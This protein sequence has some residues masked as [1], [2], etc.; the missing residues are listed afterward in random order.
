MAAPLRYSAV[1]FDLDGTLV[2]SYEALTDAVNHCLSAFDRPA[3]TAEEIRQHVGEGVETLLRRC[4]GDGSV[5]AEAGRIFEDRYDAVCCAGSRMLEEVEVTLGQLARR[6]VRMG[7]CTNKP[8]GFSRKI[9]EHLGVAAHFAAIVGPDLAGARKPDAAH[10]DFVLS[11]ISADPGESLFVG[12]MPIDV[13]A[14]RNAGLDVAVIATGSSSPEDL[15]RETPDF[16]LDRFSELME[17][18]RS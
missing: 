14:A 2:D 16:F 3:L 12:D 10:V 13:R 15:R 18:V 6:G 11:S 1:V 8:T 4:F 5:P 9:L 17:L 7:V